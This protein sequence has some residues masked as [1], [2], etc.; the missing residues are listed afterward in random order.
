M[1]TWLPYPWLDQ[2]CQAHTP[3]GRPGGERRPAVGHNGPSLTGQL[4]PQATHQQQGEGGETVGR[5]TQHSFHPKNT[6]QCLVIRH[7]HIN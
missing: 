3:Q 4:S 2:Q 6:F 1:I 5:M 7:E